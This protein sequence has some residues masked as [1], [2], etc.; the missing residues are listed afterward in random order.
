MSDPLAAWYR[1]YA[2][3][4]ARECAEA[5]RRRRSY[6]SD[7]RVEDSSVLPV[8]DCPSHEPDT[9]RVTPGRARIP[10]ARDWGA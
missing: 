1:T 2:E 8:T 6:E 4:A 7:M 10:P 3:F 5:N 9:E